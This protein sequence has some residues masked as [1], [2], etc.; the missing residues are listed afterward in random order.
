MKVAL[1]NDTHAG[2]RN[3]SQIFIDYQE[4]FYKEVFFPYLKKHNISHILHLGDYYEHRKFINFK[5]LDANNTHFLDV[6]KDEG[7]TM[8]IFPGN[9]D[10][11][12]KSTNQLCSLGTLMSGY[13]DCVHIHMDPIDLELEDGSKVA[14][15][16]WINNEN[17]GDIMSFVKRSDASICLGHFEFS[18]FELYPG[19][20]AQH[21]MAT[22][23]FKK[24]DVVLSGHYHTKSERGNVTYLGAQMEFTWGDVDD[25]KYFHILDTETGEIEAI[26]NPITLFQRVVY[27]DTLWNYN[28]FDHSIFEDKFVKIVVEKKTDPYLFDKFIDK[29]QK[30]DIHDLKI[31]ETFDEI[32]TDALGEDIVFEETTELMDKYV[33]LIDTPMEKDRLKAKLRELYIEAQSMEYE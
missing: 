2:A 30:Q 33:D 14:M 11:Y 9:H 4:R 32:M 24:F 21:G 22:D 7:Y 19:T 20:I 6:L 27:N 5:A 31:V 23:A 3:S 8:D 12:Y 25:P 1:L 13:T 29:I 28:D 16:P 17:Y 26:L 10:V 18:G 15:I